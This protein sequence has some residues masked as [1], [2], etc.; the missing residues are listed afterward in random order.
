MSE[1]LKATLTGERV[2]AGLDK[3]R[4]KAIAKAQEKLA[5]RLMMVVVLVNADRESGKP[6]RGMAGRIS[7]KLRGQIKER[8]VA[9]YL[10]RLSSGADLVEQ[11]E[12]LTNNGG[13]YET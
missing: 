13:A 9:K 3:G 7:R 5:R 8:Q 11:T 12:R 10:A 4:S 6:A 1:R 2:L